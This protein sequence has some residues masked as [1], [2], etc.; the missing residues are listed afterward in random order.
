[1][2]IEVGSD[3]E[4]MQEVFL[5]RLSERGHTIDSELFVAITEPLSKIYAIPDH[6]HALANMLGDGLVPSNAKAGYLARMIARRVLRMR[7]DLGLEVS[8]ADL[9]LHHLEVNYSVS[10]MKQTQDGLVTILKEKKRDMMRCCVKVPKWS[11]LP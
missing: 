9:A 7:D 2:N 3:G 1:M 4:R 11:R 5:S 10:R 8:L 6:L